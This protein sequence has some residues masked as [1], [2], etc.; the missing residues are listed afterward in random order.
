MTDTRPTLERLRAI[1]SLAGDRVGR[2]RRIAAAIRGAGEYRWAGIYDVTAEEIAILAWNGPGP[3]THLR[4][5]A[6]QGLC[7]AAVSSRSTV[8]ASDVSKDP[9]YLTTLGTTRSEIIVPVLASDGAAV[10]GLIDVESERAD[11]FGADDRRLLEEC[12][13]AL[14]PL[15]V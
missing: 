14:R 9:R 11:A 3:P 5:P 4:F 6:S 1:V 15:W 7:G 10:R 12:A 13:A 8:I 2:A